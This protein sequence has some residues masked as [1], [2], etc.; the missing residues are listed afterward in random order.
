LNN[1]EKVFKRRILLKGNNINSLI[2]FN[3]IHPGSFG[4]RIA[5]MALLAPKNWHGIKNVV[6]GREKLP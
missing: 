3:G 5:K 2:K 4:K 1:T 6:N